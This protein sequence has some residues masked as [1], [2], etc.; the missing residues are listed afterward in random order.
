MTALLL[1]SLPVAAT[2]PPDLQAGRQAY[3]KCMGCHSPAYNRTGPLHCGLLGRES[4][5]VEA[6]DYSEAMRDADVTW[7]R[8]TLDSFLAAP[9]A[10]LPGTS[11]GFA[12]ISDASERRNLIAWLATLDASSELCRGIMSNPKGRT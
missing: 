1:L 7:D 9:L 2:P 5:S 12:G 4:A 6:Y 8:D 10:M 3:A 11:M